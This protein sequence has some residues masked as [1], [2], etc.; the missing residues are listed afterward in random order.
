MGGTRQLECRVEECRI[1]ALRWSI[2]LSLCLCPFEPCG[3]LIV[4]AWW[5]HWYAAVSLVI[6]KHFSKWKSSLICCQWL[7]VWC[8]CSCY[9]RLLVFNEAGD[10]NAILL[11]VSAAWDWCGGCVGCLC[12]A[13]KLCLGHDKLCCSLVRCCSGTVLFA[14]NESTVERRDISCAGR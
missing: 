1:V 14:E 8:N 9:S 11:Q 4:P 6:V 5:S 3:K 10:I 2:K 12:Y 7:L 13:N